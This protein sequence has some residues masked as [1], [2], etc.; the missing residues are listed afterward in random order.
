[1]DTEINIQKVK[2]EFSME[3]EESA[4]DLYSGWHS[5]Y[6]SL[7]ER[8]VERVLAQYDKE[9]VHLIIE[10][11]ELDLGEIPKEIFYEKFP[12]LLEEKLEELMKRLLI[13]GNIEEIKK[14]SDHFLLFET[15][16]YFLVHG[17]YPWP[18]NKI[19]DDFK[20][21]FSKILKEYPDEFRDFLF[22]YGHYSSLRLRLVLQLENER[23][24]ELVALINRVESPFII[25]YFNLLINEETHRKVGAEKVKEYRNACWE[26]ILAYL[27]VK[28]GSY[29]NR[30]E[31][32]SQTIRE[33]A[34][35]Y[36]IE[37][38]MF[39][40]FLTT[41]AVNY[42]KGRNDYSELRKIL[43]EL[44][45]VAISE[46][47]KDEAEHLEWI[48]KL[49]EIIQRNSLPSEFDVE[50]LARYLANESFRHQ[51]ISLLSYQKLITL[52]EIISVKTLP[53]FPEIETILSTLLETSIQQTVESQ[54]EIILGFRKESITPAIYL[55]GIRKLLKQPLSRRALLAKL[56]E[57]AIHSL[58]KT[59]IPD[60]SVFIISYAQN[61][62]EQKEK[63]IFEGKAGGEFRQLKWEFIFGVLIEDS[64][65]SFNRKS[66][67]S[68][69]LSMLSSHYNIKLFDLLSY[70]Y[71]A[72]LDGKLSAFSDLTALFKDLY[73]E[74]KAEKPK[75]QEVNLFDKAARETFYSTLLKDFIQTGIVGDKIFTDKLFDILDYLETYRPDLLFSIIEELK[76]GFALTDS[77]TFPHHKEFYRRLIMFS[78]KSYQISLPGGQIVK[79][80]F[81]NIDDDRY[82]GVSVSTFK[83]LLLALLRND[84][85]LYEKAWNILT[86]KAGRD[87]TVE[88]TCLSL[89][90]DEVLLKI[91]I[92]SGEGELQ[93]LI[94]S[95]PKV[96]IQRAFSSITLL[97]AFVEC[98]QIY[99]EIAWQLEKA[100]KSITP[101]YFYERLYRLFPTEAESLKI[102][103]RLLTVVHPL[104]DG[105]EYGRIIFEMIVCLVENKKP[106]FETVIRQQ[107]RNGLSIQQLEITIDFLA[108]IK[109]S[110]LN[111]TL[112]KSIETIM[113]EIGDTKEDINSVNKKNS[114][115]EKGFVAWL[116]THFGSGFDFSEVEL[117]KPRSVFNPVAF[118]AF[119]KL[120][121][122][123]TELIRQ[124]VSELKLSKQKITVW[125]KEAPESLQLRWLQIITPP[126]QKNVVE[127]A[128]ILIDWLQSAFTK[129]PGNAFQRTEI[130]Q[131]LLDFSSGKLQHI[132]RN[133][134]FNRILA[135][136]LNRLD[137]TEREIIVAEI[138]T[139][140]FNHGQLWGKRIEMVIHKMDVEEKNEVV[141]S[142][143]KP[144]LTQK[145]ISSEESENLE[146]IYISN[147]GLVLCSPFLPQLFNMLG[148]LQEG[149]F[150]DRKLNER[151]V[152]LLQYMLYRETYFPEYQM[153]LNKVLCGLTTGTPI[154]C[155]IDVTN[156]EKEIIEQMLTGMIQHWGKLGNTSVIGLIESFLR[157]E[158]KLVQ[159]EDIWQLTVE[160]KGIDVLLDSIPWSY[161]P[162]KFRW[163]KKAINV[164][165]R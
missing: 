136:C 22:N 59:L 161:S 43:I 130:I 19:K 71:K 52:S 34:A 121:I 139:K 50:T 16:T 89:I 37:Y 88:I 66:F 15:F 127:E 27:L 142:N 95:E 110:S 150:P 56:N 8:V 29:F 102:F 125:I 149:I 147:A 152:L 134:L 10:K 62:D 97:R 163:M 103:F 33:L 86:E 143:V 138:R 94:S 90:P 135:L 91:I 58:V 68:S 73:F 118:S 158:G 36:N 28:K 141:E 146:E 75:L 104:S 115:E 48:E 5:F 9:D 109:I 61:L 107:I 7:F 82:R 148:L 140:A 26:L 32:V 17:F 123:Q 35:H 124:L 49:K 25:L 60:E 98:Y 53:G 24:E 20:T 6:H 87:M 23:M 39:L 131:L 100:L 72:I 153:V 145:T 14:I 111:S 154:D 165:W 106:F 159:R 129:F 84:T 64:D 41:T 4:F 122:E 112:K 3:N 67:V 30:R 116:V 81:G 55:T 13:K 78:V 21:L 156:K 76:K 99:P 38:T 65:I 92:M 2:F 126:Y 93:P 47:G 114:F 79:S 70:I 69:V 128:F 164:K 96:F 117:T 46:S 12:L 54:A 57:Q 77:T 18:G 63:N 119:E 155:N 31:F 162:I 144:A 51:I 42:L 83:T 113:S 1:M 74:L 133:E 120:V 160:Q 151:A 132:D 137:N 101:G 108:T 80:L 45:S 157:R 105:A 40:S 11:I 44:N 85:I